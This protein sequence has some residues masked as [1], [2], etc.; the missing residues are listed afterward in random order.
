MD[1]TYYTFAFFVFILLVILAWFYGRV[2]RKKTDMGSQ[3]KEQRLYRLYQNIEDMMSGFEEYAESA[4]KEIS[5][6]VEKL[7][8]LLDEAKKA[9]QAVPQPEYT[10]RPEYAPRPEYVPQPEYA[11]QPEYVQSV[12]APAVKPQDETQ[13]TTEERISLL[14]QRGMDKAEIAKK[15]GMSVREVSLIMDIKKITAQG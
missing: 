6:G 1:I 3:E 5:E 14:A 2:T 7:Q 8:S 11:T 4:K 9:M 10:P 15:L 13:L 12:K